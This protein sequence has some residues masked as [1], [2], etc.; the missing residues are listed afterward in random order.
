VTQFVQALAA[1]GIALTQQM[2]IPAEVP[3]AY[4][5]QGRVLAFDR[6]TRVAAKAGQI[7]GNIAL[8]PVNLALLLLTNGHMNQL[9]FIG[10]VSGYRTEV[11]YQAKVVNLKTQTTVLAL[12]SW[13]DFQSL[14]APISL[15]ATIWT[16][17]GGEV[18]MRDWWPGQSL[19]EEDGDQVWFQPGLD[20]SGTRIRCLRWLPGPTLDAKV[21]ERDLAMGL[22]ATRMPRLLAAAERD[23]T[24]PALSETEGSLYLQ[25]L[26][27]GPE[28]WRARTCRVKLW[29]PATGQVVGLMQVSKGFWRSHTEGDWVRR[30]Q[31]H[32]RN[33]VG[34]ATGR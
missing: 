10:N 20:L 26:C 30:I 23:G 29:D 5:V 21:A 18:A 7:I 27:P 22:Q 34:P 25:G 33:Q 12:Q 2:S 15:P 9:L 14:Q 24:G 16:L 11:L 8:V 31:R 17:G 32:L 4:R 6:Q 19:H 13:M 28:P 3:P 1:E